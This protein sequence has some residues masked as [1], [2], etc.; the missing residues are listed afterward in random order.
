ML[1]LAYWKY[2]IAIYDN[3]TAFEKYL[4]KQGTEEAAR[5]AGVKL[6]QKHSIV[7]HVCAFQ[8]YTAVPTE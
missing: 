2:Y 3:S 7:P 4:K 1:S 8:Q 6:K 5:K